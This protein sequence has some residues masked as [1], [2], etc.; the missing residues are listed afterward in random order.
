MKL[1]K[2]LIS[3]SIILLVIIGCGSGS[4]LMESGKIDKNRGEH[5]KAIENFKAEIALNPQN[6]EAWYWKGYCEEKLRQWVEMKNSYTQSIANS[7]GFKAKIDKSLEILWMTYYNESILALDS[8]WW[9]KALSKLDTAAI[10]DPENFLLYR[11]AATV[12]K[13]AGYSQRAIDY[14]LIAYQYPREFNDSLDISS[15]LLECYIDEKNLDEVI[16]W[17]K[18]IISLTEPRSDDEKLGSYYLFGIDNL[19]DAYFKNDMLSEAEN[20]FA[21]AMVKFPENKTLK[22]N[23]AASMVNR[24]DYDNAMEVYEKL[25]DVEPGNVDANLQI[26]LMLIIQGEEIKDNEDLKL[27]KY[28]KSIPYLEKVVELDP[29]NMPATQSLPAV[30]FAIGDSVKGKAMTQRYLKLMREGK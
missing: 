7:G 24:K 26:G 6:G 14:G 20:V 8:L 29:S 11:Q 27:A 16:V 22:L 9:D 3:V 10:F 13:S 4:Y 19:A 23:L 21:D 2:R 1:Y 25:L 15:F 18:N 12:S 5:V 17:S 30:Y 28:K